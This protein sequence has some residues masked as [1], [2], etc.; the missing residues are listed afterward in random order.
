M[1]WKMRVRDHP[2]IAP[3][4]IVGT[5]TANGYVLPP[6]PWV[7][8][9]DLQLSNPHSVKQDNRVRSY[10][11]A[12]P[13]SGMVQYKLFIA[14]SGASSPRYVARSPICR[15]SYERSRPITLARNDAGIWKV[16]E[17]SSVQV[18]VA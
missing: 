5:H 8:R 12:F 10:F 18:G 7:V 13:L 6:A 2:H 16:D 4:Y 17:W 15:G 3:S 1:D 9:V 14:C 11:D